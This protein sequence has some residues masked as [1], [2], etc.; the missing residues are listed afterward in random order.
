M[1]INRTLFASPV[2]RKAHRIALKLCVGLTLVFPLTVLASNESLILTKVEVSPA[3]T[4]FSQ[5][6]LQEHPRVRAA[7]SDVTAAEARERAASKALYNP[8]LEAEYEDGDVLTRS[9]GIKQTIDLGGKRGARQRATSFE[10]QSA[11]ESLALIRQT[12]LAELLSA[13]GMYEITSEQLLIADERK[14]LVGRLRTLTKERWQ[15]GDL[16][17]VEVDLA[18]LA[19][20]QAALQRSQSAGKLVTAEQAL[21]RV[22]GNNVPNRPAIPSIYASV[23]IDEPAIDTILT[24]LPSVRIAQA[25]I[26]TAQA[27]VDLRQRERR[28]D[29]TIGLY[30]GREGS[31]DLVG[32]R[33]S[34]PLPVRNSYRAE[35]DAAN[36][37][38]VT[39]DYSITD[40]YRHLR[41][42]LVAAERRY[43]IARAAWNEWLQ[44]G[45]GSLESQTDLLERLW[46]AGELNTMEYLVQLHQTLDTRVAASEQREA[47]WE[48]WIALLTV[49]GQIDTWV[50]F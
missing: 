31:A 2:C 8:E 41:A 5:Q 34:I 43:E 27:V 46:H 11:I 30:A 4:T 45:A 37:D 18:N 38:L 25:R 35:V 48:A 50:G 17:Q 40:E 32:V 10:T 1:I 7:Q 3:L 9:I 21:A 12:V 29:P 14:T 22:A 42:E 26:A 15:A 24:E 23:T 36:A 33:F 13:L 6:V 44:V 16:N 20:A 49:S 28:P 19:Y 39:L 47:L